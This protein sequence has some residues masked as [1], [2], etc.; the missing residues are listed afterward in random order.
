VQTDPLQ[1]SKRIVLSVLRGE[2]EGPWPEE[3]DLLFLAARSLAVGDPAW[4]LAR[5]E[6]R[7]FPIALRL[8][9]WRRLVGPVR[10]AAE[11]RLR[12]EA[13]EDPAW[14]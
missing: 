1:R 10:V 11:V 12:A 6:D 13:P 9:V 4:L 3:D 14:R 2:L 8:E 7:A 5:L